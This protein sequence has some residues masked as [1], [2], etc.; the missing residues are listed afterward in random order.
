VI[1]NSAWYYCWLDE[2][3]ILYARNKGYGIIQPNGADLSVG[4]KAE[5]GLDWYD[6]TVSLS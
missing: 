6:F 2:D 1:I 5:G 4:F 3:C